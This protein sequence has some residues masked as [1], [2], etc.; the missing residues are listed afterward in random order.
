MFTTLIETLKNKKYV[1]TNSDVDGILSASLLCSVFPNL[2]I[3]GFT[4]S[5]NKIWVLKD[6]S[7]RNSVYV[8]IYMCN[9]EILSI[10]NHIVSINK[11]VVHNENNKI[12][13]NI[14]RKRTFMDYWTKYPF[15]TFIFI[16][17]IM[18]RSGIKINMNIE[19]KIGETNN[20]D[21][22]LWELL[23]RC[24]DTLVSTFRY[25]R[26]AKEW[27]DYILSDNKDSVLF[28]LHN[29]L[30][31]E[32]KNEGNANHIKS[33]VNL[34]LKNK[35]RYIN[36]DGYKDINIVKNEFNDFTKFISGLYHHVSFSVDNLI[37]YNLNAK[38][39]KVTPNTDLTTVNNNMISLAF[40]NKETI[41][42]T[43]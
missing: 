43:F 40:V 38:R 39:V 41:S 1:V 10:D 4:N 24:D 12:N 42:F 3:G 13:P 17:Y 31:Y 34:F 36:N 25:H 19:T 32:V 5:D 30:L 20:E 9:D 37:T 15:S 21:V 22:F 14:L 11:F 8:D 28:Q 29:K 35:F 18:E 33:K 7:K 23:L 26:N 16:L 2:E 27:W 6:V